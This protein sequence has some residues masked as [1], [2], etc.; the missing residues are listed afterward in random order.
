METT[1]TDEELHAFVA[2]ILSNLDKALREPEVIED[3]IA[4]HRQMWIALYHASSG[5]GA[6]G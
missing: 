1:P 3:A 6:P 5:F 2:A 4:R